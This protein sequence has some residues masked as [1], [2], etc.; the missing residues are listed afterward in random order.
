LLTSSTASCDLVCFSHH[1][2]PC[3]CFIGSG[4]PVS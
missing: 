3:S 4:R 1:V 2:S